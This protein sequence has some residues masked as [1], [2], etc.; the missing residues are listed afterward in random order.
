MLARALKV[1]VW[2][3]L[4]CAVTDWSVPL[5]L[6]LQLGPEQPVGPL[7]QL[8][9]AEVAFALA[10]NVKLSFLGTVIG[11]QV[12]GAV[13]VQVWVVLTLVSVTVIVPPPAPAKVIV[14]LLVLAA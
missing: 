6:K 3:S 4:N 11:E 7:V 12:P 8:V 9:K 5:M 10:V 14:R 13:L 2:L 1:M